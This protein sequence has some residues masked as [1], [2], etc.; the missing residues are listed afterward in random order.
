MNE[1]GWK[2]SLDTW[3]LA[4]RAGLASTK[5]LF[6]QASLES[7]YYVWALHSN[8][9]GQWRHQRTLL[10]PIVSGRINPCFLQCFPPPVQ[11]RELC[12]GTKGLSIEQGS[13]CGFLLSKQ[14]LISDA[15]SPARP[16]F[17]N[18]ERATLCCWREGER[19]VEGIPGPV[20]ETNLGWCFQSSLWWRFRS[21]APSG[22]GGN[23]CLKSFCWSWLHS[24]SRSRLQIPI[25]GS[26]SC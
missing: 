7:R 2:I 11:S 17:G 6:Q 5:G 26:A 24:I 16:P 14:L 15:E 25:A 3:G 9:F 20:P 10:L 13:N 12:R 4:F 8:T 1:S 19:E 18:R 22:T 21:P 23:F